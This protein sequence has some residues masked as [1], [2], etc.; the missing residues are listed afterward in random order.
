MIT[1]KINNSDEWN[2]ELESFSAFSP[3]MYYN[4]CEVNKFFN[5]KSIWIKINTEDKKT[6]VYFKYKKIFNFGLFWSPQTIIGDLDLL[7]T[8]NITDFLK[9]EIKISYIYIRVNLFY[10]N[11]DISKKILKNNKWNLPNKKIIASPN[12]VIIK[13]YTTDIELKTRISK[14]FYKTIKKSY[15]TYNDDFK[16]TYLKNFDISKIDDLFEEFIKIKKIEI[17]YLKKLN[18]LKKKC[19]NKLLVGYIEK[20]NKIISLRIVFIGNKITLDFINLTNKIGRIKLSNY[21]ITNQ[22]LKYLF[23]NN[24]AEKFDFSGIDEKNNNE[25]ARFKMG[26]SGKSYITNLGEYD[27]SNNYLY[28]VI[29]KFFLFFY[30]F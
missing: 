28:Y 6:L 24:L 12:T 10:E 15:N 2:K 25:V 8:K 29:L 22:L 1:K 4:F 23:K 7:K 11:N 26:F 30:K 27:Y 20:D 21:F 3:Y 16:I 13:P 9:K 14:N 19:G 5:W 18:F 17:S